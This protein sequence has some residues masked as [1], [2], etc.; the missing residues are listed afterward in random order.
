MSAGAC[1]EEETSPSVGASPP[2]GDTVDTLEAEALKAFKAVPEAIGSANGGVTGTRS[3]LHRI[4]ADMGDLAAAG[5]GAAL[6][7][8]ALA[9][10][11]SQLATVSGDIGQAMDPAS[12]KVDEAVASARDARV[13]IAELARAAEEIVGAVDTIASITR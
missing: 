13:L 3:D 8:V 11:A 10:S 2:I 6:Q 7:T 12:A 1:E 9:A 5:S 4:H